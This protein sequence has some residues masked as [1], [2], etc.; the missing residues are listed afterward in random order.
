MKILGSGGLIS[1]ILAIGAAGLG[2]VEYVS[3]EKRAKANIIAAL[4]RDDPVASADLILQAHDM[5]AVKLERDEIDKLLRVA[6][7]DSAQVT[8]GGAMPASVR[9]LGDD[10]SPAALVV[11]L[12][13]PDLETRRAATE[14]FAARFRAERAGTEALV[15]RLESYDAAPLSTAGLFN[16]L[17][18]VTAQDGSTWDDA[19]R[20]RCFQAL[21]TLPDDQIRGTRL[22]TL[23]DALSKRFAAA[24][25]KAEARSG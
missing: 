5:G 24:A 23:A 1:A 3:Q 11:A 14:A 19:L 25:A 10:A 20:V 13:S 7:R 21:Q 15:A 9:T 6:A 2:F 12:D 17:T 18:L 8:A 16:V 4:V 22:Q